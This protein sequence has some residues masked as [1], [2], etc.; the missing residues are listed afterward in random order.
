MA[1]TA[2]WI[3]LVATCVAA[4]MTASNLGARTT[5]WGFVIFTLGAAA[6]ITVGVAT[7]QTQLLY[8]NIFL[9]LVDVFGVWRWLGRRARISDTAR[10]EEEKSGRRAG[11][12]LFST[13]KIDGL[14]VK[15]SDGEVLATSVDALA[16]CDGGRIDF[17]IIRAG[18]IGGVGETLYRL[19]WSEARVRDGEITTTLSRAALSRLTVADG[20]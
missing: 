18:G 16:A 8:S 4:L 19:P 17:L 13:G 12:S 14:P 20:G 6:W 10:A 1:D 3:A 5:G 9:G 15:S 11:E 7:H 2:G